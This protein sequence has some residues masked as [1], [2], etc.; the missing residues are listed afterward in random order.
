MADQ[1]PEDF[2]AN[3]IN[4]VLAA[5][6]LDPDPVPAGE[7]LL[8]TAFQETG[9]REAN[10]VQGGGGPALGLFQ[11]EP[12]THNDIW[13]NFLAYRKDL[14]AKVTAFL[15]AGMAPAAGL[16]RDNDRYAAAMTRV[17]YFRMG[18]THAKAPLPA[19]GDIAAMGAYWKAYYNG[20]GKGTAEQ[21]VANWNER[22]PQA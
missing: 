14:A 8:G 18:Q 20:P 15:P 19:A 22:M 10:R 11:M 21:F 4:P 13:A 5:L 16:V 6:G 2:L 17:H 9:L 12:N 7:L 1:S 3:V